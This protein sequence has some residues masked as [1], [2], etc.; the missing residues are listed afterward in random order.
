MHQTAN[1]FK[2]SMSL[3]AYVLRSLR[4]NYGSYRKEDMQHTFQILKKTL[5]WTNIADPIVQRMPIRERRFF[6]IKSA[7]GFGRHKRHYVFRDH[8]YSLT[9]YD[10]NHPRQLVAASLGSMTP[11][12]WCDIHF[13]WHYEG[14]GEK[15]S[16]CELKFNNNETISD[17]EV[18]NRQNK[19]KLR[20]EKL[21]REQ[22]AI[23]R[24]KH[25]I[26][27]KDITYGGIKNKWNRI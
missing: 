3:A 12:A 7:R 18:L 27:S 15:S 17:E 11:D 14:S 8:R 6:H 24:I 21:E 23:E 5:S 1:F 2:Y 26:D 10:V 25:K 4:V 9:F 13:A 20:L 19:E 22:R 16:T